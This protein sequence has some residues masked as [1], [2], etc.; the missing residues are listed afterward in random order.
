[1]TREPS[2]VWPNDCDSGFRLFTP[3]ERL[4]AIHL[5]QGLSNKEISTALGRSE[6]TIKNQISSILRRTGLPSR[7]R[8][9]ALY[10]REFLCP[11]PSERE[12]QR[13]AVG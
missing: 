1:M 7:A 13:A 10:A 5:A 9:I 12:Q 11:L 2:S 4:V 3:A 8:F 6:A